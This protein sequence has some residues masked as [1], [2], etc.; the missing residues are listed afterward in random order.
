[1]NKPTRT[2][3][4]NTMKET[5]SCEFNLLEARAL[6]DNSCVGITLTRFTDIVWTNSKFDEMFG[7]ASGELHGQNARI[8]YLS[9]A[10]FKSVSHAAHASITGGMPYEAELPM[11]RKDGDVFWA[12]FTGKAINPDDLEVGVIWVVEDIDLRK[13][14]EQ[15]LDYKTRQLEFLNNTL[16]QR[17]AE[18]VDALK[19]KELML[20]R[21]TR[22]LVELA[23]EAIIVFDMEQ[24]QIIDANAHA[25]QLFGCSKFELFE[26]SPL[27][28]YKHEQPDGAMPFES[29][30]RNNQL[31][32][33]GEVL[34]FERVIVSRQGDESICEM[35]LVRMPAEGRSL[36]RASII[37]ITARKREQAELAT[38]LETAQRSMEE[39]KQFIGLISHE[40]RTPL[41]I[42]DGTAQLLS[43]SACD[44]SECLNH[45]ERI[46]I[47]SRRI[48]DLVDTCLTEERMAA[49]GWEPRIHMER[50]HLI[51]RDV[52]EKVQAGTANHRIELDLAAL[53]Q[54]CPC[55][56]TLFRVMLTNLLDNAIK[57]S[58]DGGLISLRGWSDQTGAIRIRVSDQGI[59][60]DPALADKIFERFFRIWQVPGIAGA[61]LGLHLV[62]RIA[63][64]HGGGV[65]AT[66]RPGL[67]ADFT[68]WLRA[69]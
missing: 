51:L 35:R 55:D 60:F 69:S 29:F 12:R 13:G 62:K 37:D 3:P 61:G 46:R 9:D 52:V 44:N 40:L 22:L 18:A 11:R 24:G 2:T 58:P 65:E 43:L 34:I 15:A 57:Y 68:V 6:L 14:A 66:S 47:A 63:M 17:I 64:L 10:V 16:E 8:F 26:T 20:H 36:I 38:A 31:V 53:P 7:Y 33:N 28:F 42:I 32:M 56:A 49:T 1:M 59:G 25:E 27:T 48:T 19:Q 30:Q 4:T 54:H 45:A 23:P 67:G 21:Q 50:I 5:N 39:Q 41:A